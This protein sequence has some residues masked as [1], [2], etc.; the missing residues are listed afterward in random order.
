[1][2]RVSLLALFDIIFAS[3]TALQAFDR[4]DKKSSSGALG[5]DESNCTKDN[6][7]IY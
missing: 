1:M 4:T 7:A 6:R 3:S 5:D 2:K